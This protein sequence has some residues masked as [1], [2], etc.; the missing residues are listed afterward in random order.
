MGLYGFHAFS[1]TTSTTQLYEYSSLYGCCTLFWRY[2]SIDILYGLTIFWTSL[3]QSP[4]PP[5]SCAAPLA[6]SLPEARRCNRSR[7]IVVVVGLVLIL[8]VVV[9]FSIVF[10]VG[11]VPVLVL[12]LVLV[13]VL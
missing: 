13:I 1:A 10:V 8:M 9:V 11:L 5:P 4:R 6:P 7:C 2:L 3:R 12:V